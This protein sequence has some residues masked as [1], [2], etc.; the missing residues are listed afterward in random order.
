VLIAADRE[1]QFQS[2]LASRDVIGQA[3]G[4]VMERCKIDAVRAFALLTR[5][6]QDANVQ[7]RVIAQQLVDSSGA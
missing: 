3:K 4:V 6:S 5:L 1:T 7:V 2:A